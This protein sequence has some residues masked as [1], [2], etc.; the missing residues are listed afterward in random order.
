[1]LPIYKWIFLSCFLLV[2]FSG[3]AQMQET[4]VRKY[5]G[6]NWNAIYNISS[7]AV[8]GWYKEY[9]SSN[10]LICENRI[11]LPQ[12][13]NNISANQ[14]SNGLQKLFYNNGIC[15]Y[16]AFFWSNR[17][18]GP[19]LSRYYNGLPK[20][21]SYAN[22]LELFWLPDS[23]LL[24]CKKNNAGSE[25]KIDT[26]IESNQLRIV[27]QALIAANCFQL[28]ENES[29]LEVISFEN[30]KVFTCGL[31]DA[32]LHGAFQCYAFKNHV[33]ENGYYFEGNPCGVWNYYNLNKNFLRK[34]TTY[35]KSF[36]AGA[37]PLIEQEYNDET[38]LISKINRYKNG[39][40]SGWQCTYHPN[41]MIAD[42]FFVKNGI[43]AGRHY[44]MQENG[45]PF[46]ILN[47]N[48]KGKQSG[49][50]RYW[51]TPPYGNLLM[52]EVN[53][54]DGMR[55]GKARYYYPNGKLK[56]QGIYQKDLMEKNWSWFD[57]S[58][59]VLA[60]LFYVDGKKINKDSLWV[61]HDNQ[62][63][64]RFINALESLIDLDANFFIPWEFSYLAPI[65]PMVKNCFADYID[66]GGDENNYYFDLVAFEPIYFEIP[67]KGGIQLLLNPCWHLGEQS[68]IPTSVSFA[69]NRPEETNIRMHPKSLAYVFPHFLKDEDG[70]NF[71]LNFNLNALEATPMQMSFEGAVAKLP[72][73]CYL[74]NSNLQL[75]L[76]SVQINAPQQ[77]QNDF[78]PMGEV[79]GFMNLAFKGKMISI[80]IANL[81]VTH[82]T[83][84]LSIAPP[85]LASAEDWCNFLKNKF[86]SVEHYNLDVNKEI[87]DG[88]LL[89]NIEMI[90]E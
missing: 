7:G 72:D 59:S 82:K 90:F 36:G 70:R 42:S 58:E 31:K 76:N 18:I 12:D 81:Q 67:N 21:L 64:Q 71:S 25:K 3:I 32:R 26:L 1:M 30:E 40:L 78:N 23:S 51:F 86:N 56:L 35:S 52:E 45:L 74:Q 22:G 44:S 54:K 13:S 17:Q 19:S 77:G 87:V 34:K 20:C 11:I 46:G 49:L 8:Q 80:P 15:A 16:S 29:Q 65:W 85:D 88:K 53:Y 60:E 41:G 14:I 33:F 5:E 27:Y 66:F 55:E 10:F 48:K 83:L 69:E 63:S 4:R 38:G 73:T 79:L 50:N 47:Y 62:A 75:V 24:Y 43:A 61:C 57:T 9:D 37:L 39:L 84:I 2:N 89:L 28:F 6:N 68:N